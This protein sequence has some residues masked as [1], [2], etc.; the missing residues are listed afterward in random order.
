MSVEDHNKQLGHPSSSSS[1]SQE[2]YNIRMAGI[3][4]LWAAIL[5]TD[6]AGP[7]ET[8]PPWFRPAQGWRWLA[9]ILRPPFP[10][11]ETT[12]ILVDNFLS[13]AG[14]RLAGCYVRQFVKVLRCLLEEGIGQDKAGFSKKNRAG[15]VKLQLKLEDWAKKGR[16]VS[17]EGREME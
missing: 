13:V 17:I 16:V 7:P 1:E 6:P 5:Q 9:L 2:Q 3:V 12:A 15:V 11:L 8:V 14:E 4:A 10:G